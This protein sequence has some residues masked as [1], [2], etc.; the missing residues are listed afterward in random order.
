MLPNYLAKRRV[1]VTPPP[2]DC[3]IAASLLLREYRS[4]GLEPLLIINSIDYLRNLRLT[5]NY[6]LL[7]IRDEFKDKI[8]EG[9]EPLF[10]NINER[11]GGVFVWR[12]GGFT[13]LELIEPPPKSMTKL[14]SQILKVTS[15]QVE[16]LA[17]IVEGRYSGLTIEDLSKA[18]L[19]ALLNIS[20][21]YKIVE[22]IL[23]GNLNGFKA[24]IDELVE[25]Y[26]RD[27]ARYVAEIKGKSMRLRNYVLIYYD[28][29]SKERIYVSEV[30]DEF[31]NEGYKGFII[32]GSRGDKVVKIELINLN[33]RDK[34]AIKSRLSGFIED[35]IVVGDIDK[36]YLRYPFPNLHELIKI[37]LRI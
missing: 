23:E 8:R 12:K 36:L 14:M 1:I 5:S 15:S 16:V 17:S 25:S 22:L 10:L 37:V 18:S 20:N 24:L 34:L 35:E 6:A 7:C 29:Y 30:I 13:P 19:T 26:G 9:E 2:L 31:I 27:E 21:F 11:F 28:V 3:I 33:M 32:L 4:E